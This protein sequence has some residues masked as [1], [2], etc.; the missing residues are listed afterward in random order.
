M[1]FQIPPEHA[2][3]LC[4]RIAPHKGRCELTGGVVD[5]VN[6]IDRFP[7]RVLVRLGL[8]SERGKQSKTT[9][10]ALPRNITSFFYKCIILLYLYNILYNIRT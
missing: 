2:H 4:R 8:L 9:G 6:Q 5:Q 10:S 7:A 1:L 3:V